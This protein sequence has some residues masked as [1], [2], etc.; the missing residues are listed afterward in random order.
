TGDVNGDGYD[1]IV[2]TRCY[3]LPIPTSY[4]QW[5]TGKVYLIFGKKS[6]WTMDYNLSNADVCFYCNNNKDYVDL[7]VTKVGD[8]N[9]DTYDD[10]LIGAGGNCD[11]ADMKG[12]TYLIFGK[13]SGWIKNYNLSNADV[14]FKGENQGDKSGYSV[15]GAGDINYDGYD[16]ILIG[17]PGYD[18]TLQDAGKTYLILGKLIG[19]S[20]VF[21]LSNSDASFIGENGND[22][23]GLTISGAGDVNGDNY[24]DFLIAAPYYNDIPHSSS[25][26]GKVYLIFGRTSGWNNGEP[27]TNANASFI[28]GYTATFLGLAI[29]AVGDVNG[30]K[31]DDFLMSETG[32][33]DG[34]FEAYGQSYLML[35]R[36]SN[37]PKNASDFNVNASFEGENGG[38]G[39]GSALSGAGDVNNDSYDDFLIGA[40]WNDDGGYRAGKIYLIL[41]KSSG[42]SGYFD[43]LNANASFIGEKNLSQLGRSVSITGDVNGDGYDDMLV[44]SPKSYSYG[45]T[46]LAFYYVDIVPTSINSISLYADYNFLIK[47]S[48]GFINQTIFVELDGIDGDTSTINIAKVT[49]NSSLIDPTGIDLKLRETGVNTGKYRGQFKISNISSQYYSWIGAIGGETITVCSVK[50]NSKFDTLSVK[51]SGIRIIPYFDNNTAL[52]DEL[53]QQKYGSAGVSEELA[54]WAHESNASWL[55]WEASIHT[56]WGTPTN[57][58]VGQYW[59]RINIS[60][61]NEFFDEH[62]F[63]LTVENVNDPPQIIGAPLELEIYAYEDY[64]LDFSD[65]IIDVDNTTD[66]LRVGVGSKYVIVNGLT[67]TFNYPNSVIYEKVN[68]VATDGIDYANVHVLNNTIIARELPVI[69]NKTPIGENVSI[70]SNI[71]ITFSNP[72]NKTSVEAAFALQPNIAG[73]FSWHTNNTLMIFTLRAELELAQEY[74]VNISSSAKNQNGSP[75]DGNMN[76][77]IDGVPLDDYSWKFRTVT[78]PNQIPLIKIESPENNSVNN[79]NDTIYFDC[80][81]STDPDGDILEFMW[82]S[83]ISGILSNEPKF[84]LNLP[85]GHHRITLFVND[86]H[87]HNVS[88]TLNIIV[89]PYNRPPIPI[90]TS[91]KNNDVFNTTDIITFDG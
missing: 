22:Q 41:G 57:D 18:S 58:D 39:L 84:N 3:I 64:V 12:R 21:Y 14:I 34:V 11:D 75:L 8:V 44:D 85:V 46:F 31:Y 25:W 47:T 86:N 73:N 59:V 43:L 88:T 79:V 17:A 48:E 29:S 53:Y 13:S 90:I 91:P 77:L 19:W 65:Y 71:S 80:T 24:D 83:N 87:N 52:E 78:T 16:D 82:H 72:M 50:D 5:Y 74:T 68:I 9:N 63:T 40:P 60:Y 26:A 45:K 61:K 70:S 23:S 76:E 89:I 32:W 33:D 55:N 10:I 2:I 20:A 1:D 54:S 4:F 42:W 36:T 15:A 62:N 51:A 27:L 66:E 49:V 56:I 28:G 81:N 35:G 37:W 67:I 38:D 6:N 7:S 69:L 30:D